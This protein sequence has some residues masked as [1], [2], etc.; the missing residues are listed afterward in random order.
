M[1]EV[2]EAQ[3]GDG[4]AAIA[5]VIK[6]HHEALGLELPQC[7]ATQLHVLQKSDELLEQSADNR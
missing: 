4:G 1:T 2:A 7:D 3:T 5:W 6:G